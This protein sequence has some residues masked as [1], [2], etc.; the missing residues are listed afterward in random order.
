VSS[1]EQ[2]SESAGQPG[3]F[4][5]DALVGR[6]AGRA[7]AA[8]GDNSYGQLNLPAYFMGVRTVAAGGRHSLALLDSAVDFGNQ[9][10]GISSAAKTFTIKSTGSGPVSIT[11]VGLTGGDA[12]DSV[13]IQPL[14]VW[15]VREASQVS[16]GRAISSR[17]H[18]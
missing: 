6:R 15:R 13:I 12:S 9:S 18:R 7:I 5:N 10:P 8:W 2:P 17:A 4:R 1:P 16:R 14:R 3:V 11:N